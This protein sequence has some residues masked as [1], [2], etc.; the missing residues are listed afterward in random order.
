VLGYGEIST[1]MQIGTSV[2]NPLA[3]KRLPL[4]RTEDE[5]ERYEALYWDYVHVLEKQVGTR[6]A[7]SEMVRLVDADKGRVTVY[8]A[9]EQLPFEA[10]GHRA[11]HHLRPDQVQ[12][13][14]LAVLKEIGRVFAFN[15][16]HTGTLEIGFDGQISNWAL[17]DV[18]SVVPGQEIPLVYLDTSTPLMQCD[19]QE[20]LDPNLF[21]RSAPSFLVWVL[22]LLFVQDVMTRYYDQRKVTIDLIANF[23]K[24]QRPELVPG[25]VEVANAFMSQ[26]FAEVH[27]S[28]LS[29]QEI[30]S[31]YR[32]DAWIWRLYLAFRKVDREL[33][34]LRRKDYPYV[35]PATIRR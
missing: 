28:P 11:I 22:R 23:Y 4:F 25:L 12:T 34:R 33:H 10:I 27:W 9:Q 35:L 17:A 32:E 2:E 31:Y 7:A 19:G 18:A 8:I 29:V 6:V 3:Y 13:L 20:Q 16:Q 21:L 15:R 5:A 24:E 14:F 30:R 1:V 26:A